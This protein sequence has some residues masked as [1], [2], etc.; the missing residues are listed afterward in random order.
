VQAGLHGGDFALYR[1]DASIIRTAEIQQKVFFF[2]KQLLDFFCERR[3]LPGQVVLLDEIQLGG[4]L[5]LCRQGLAS[6]GLLPNL[7]RKVVVCT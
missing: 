3:D 5:L 6:S 2:G 1:L 7:L 4:V